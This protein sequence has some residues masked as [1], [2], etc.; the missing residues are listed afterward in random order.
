MSKLEQALRLL[1][2]EVQLEQ[3]E[4]MISHI[5]N[6]GIAV[7][8][9]RAEDDAQFDDI[10]ANSRTDIVLVAAN[11]VLPLEQA[12]ERIKRQG[13]DIPVIAVLEHLSDEA[14]L[15]ALGKG[16][17]DAVIRGEP[18]HIRHVIRRQFL[19]LLN[20]RSVRHFEADLRES[21]RR[22]DALI[23]SSRDPIAYIH[24]GMHIRANESYLQM[25]GYESFD[26]LE[27][28]PI[29]DLIDA[30]QQAA[31][32]Q[33]VKDFAKTRQCPPSIRV[34]IHPADGSAA[35]VEFEMMPAS[36]DGELCLQLVARPQLADSQLSEQ[37]RELKDRD[38]NTMLFN[39]KYF[40]G[41][42]ETAVGR[43]GAGTGNQAVLLVEPN[44]FE[45]RTRNL[46]IGLVDQ[47]M[48]EFAAKLT[49]LTAEDGVCF[50][51]R[52]HT[53]AVLCPDSRFEDTVALCERIHAGFD[54]VLLEVGDSSIGF[55]VSVAGVQITEQNASVPE[56]LNTANRLLQS[57]DGL[58]GNRFEV[59]DP[60]AG[61]RA[62][63][64][65]DK[66]WRERILKALAGGEFVLNYQPVINLTQ[67]SDIESY[68][69]LIRLP[70]QEGEQIAPDHFLPIAQRHGLIDD[71]DRWVV[72]QAIALLAERQRRGIDTQI[73]VK[74]SPESVQDISLAHLI[75]AALRAHEVEGR[76]LILELPESQIITRLK[77]V[78][79][80]KAAI[81]PLGVRLSLTQFG[82]SVDSL[83]M[84]G[85]F[86]ADMIKIDR[87]FIEDL[88]KNPQHQAKIREF[89]QHARDL[90]KATM[91]EF[92][93]D[94]A[95]VGLL[96]SAGVD[97]IQ[98]NFLSPPLAQMNFDFNT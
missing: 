82:T 32:K 43:A 26:E 9:E 49:T 80:F 73:F 3:A 18:A 1:I 77:D 58:G 27:G 98:G 83:K 48:I 11:P 12:V 40:M 91:A 17:A 51:L 23:E 56:I 10:V 55:S 68:E 96:F 34:G 13:K 44:Q 39:R 62:D 21:E 22:C 93:S 63:A 6:G 8:P 95:T 14:V 81:K 16:A 84:L 72:G 85:H 70:S 7:R 60:A 89:V 92:V 30:G 94:A 78:Q 31:F 5:R 42:L 47:L 75:S 87:S 67:E 90:D 74:I 41:Q 53:L 15:D 50:H 2:V 57:M 19:A 35:E 45:Q 38:P 88:D 4:F 37:L 36:Y 20:R 69:L 66:A 28:M 24:D 76:R 46:D 33:I 54:N 97:W 29:L 79:A 25:F 65:L 71:I 61:E 64:E 59:F 86:D 52:D